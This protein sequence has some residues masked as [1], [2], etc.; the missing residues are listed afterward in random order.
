MENVKFV[1]FENR[2]D[3]LVWRKS[4]I[5]SSDATLLA[6]GNG[7]VKSPRW[8]S[9]TSAQ[10]LFW[11]K[12]GFS[13]E[14]PDNFAM[15]RGRDLEEDVRARA[16]DILGFISVINVERTDFP[17]VRASLDGLTMDNA[18]V[19][20][21]V[22]GKEVIELAKEG[23]VPGYYE[24]QLAHQLMALWGKPE[25]WTG[26]EKYHF[27]VFDANNDETH[28]VNGFSENLRAMATEL[29][30]LE[31][32][33]WK[34]VEAKTPILGGA[35]WMDLAM[36]IS[37]A[38]T[39]KAMSESYKDVVLYAAE[40]CSYTPQ[41]FFVRKEAGKVS[42]KI[43]WIELLK[44]KNIPRTAQDNFRADGS[45]IVR[46]GDR[47]LDLPPCSPEQAELLHKQYKPDLKS[48]TALN[49]RAIDIAMQC[50]TLAGPYGLK[51]YFKNGNVGYAKLA[52]A[53]GITPE[54]I[55]EFTMNEE[56]SPKTTLVAKRKSSSGSSAGAV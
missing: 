6:S 33:F 48:M 17:H 15:K 52:E 29:W 5:G 2:A 38:K 24:A 27:I 31:A 9:T 11:D 55:A 41:D 26:A 25:K 34:H 46:G 32:Q 37:E 35:D 14:Q 54:E 21:K 40:F 12:L 23:K 28:Y 13:K 50:G 1:N 18:I 36:E 16:E 49:Q 4:G 51:V 3:W 7:L 44:S 45:W 47:P 8:G 56:V 42:T 22:P 53:F 43:D 10:E 39:Q 20:I 30:D 19:E